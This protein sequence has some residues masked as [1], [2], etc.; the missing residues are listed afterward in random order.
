MPKTDKTARKAARRAALPPPN[1]VASY[2]VDDACAVHGFGRTWLYA[3]LKDGTF[4]KIK[5]GRRTLICAASIRAYLGGDQ[6]AG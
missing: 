5:A 2:T 6:Q 3:K 4:K 1:Q